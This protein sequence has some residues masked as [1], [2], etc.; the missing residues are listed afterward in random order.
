MG[1]YSDAGQ[2]N[3]R[4][5]EGGFDDNQVQPASF[6]LRVGGQEPI[7]CLRSSSLPGAPDLESYFKK[8]AK[9]DLSFITPPS[10]YLHKNEVYVSPIVEELNLPS[11]LVGRT[12]PKSTSGRL[13]I[14]TRCLTNSGHSFD[15]I[16]AGY[17]GKLW[18]E[19]YPRSFDQVMR[20]GYKYTQLRIM[21]KGTKPLNEDELICEHREK[22]ILFSNGKKLSEKNF[23]KHLRG[24]IVTIGIDLTGNP[25]GYSAKK[26]ADVVDP[27]GKHP[28]EKYF[29]NLKLENSE[30]VIIQ[31][32]DFCIFGSYER[33]NVPLNV[34]A[35]MVDV[36]T[37]IGEFRSHYAG[38]FDPGFH[39]Y[40]VLE[41][42][43]LGAPFSLF[44]KQSIAGLKFYHMK[45]I[46]E[47]SYNGNYKCQKGPKLAK[48]FY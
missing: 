1:V 12:N 40:A 20:G 43:N 26:I 44:H 9:H 5:K 36:D 10:L 6:D 48:C 19:L 7:Y 25:F 38:F 29:E 15:D 46:P 35:E 16:P 31:G 13:D 42:R 28:S 3:G 18:V 39:A 41:V 24:D 33:V 21:D 30:E 4:I 11:Y 32:G 2:L 45:E 47:K 17:T 22:G 8:R 14:H 37:G 34:C 27:L 23:K